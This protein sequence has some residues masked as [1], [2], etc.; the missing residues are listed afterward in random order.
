MNRIKIVH[1]ITD[2]KFGGAGRYLLEIC[3]YID[4]ERFEN[5]V[6]L[7]KGSILNS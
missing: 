6:I 5:I 3:R 7:P 2:L 4:K 1:V